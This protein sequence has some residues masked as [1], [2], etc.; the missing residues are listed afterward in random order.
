MTSASG[1]GRTGHS[2]H[3]RPYTQKFCEVTGILLLAAE[4][5]LICNHGPMDAAS[6]GTGGELFG[7]VV[8]F[9]LRSGHEP[10]F[11]DLVAA[12]MTEIARHEP[13]TLLYVSHTVEGEPR[14]RVFYELYRTLA[15]FE[16][17]ER[18]SHVRHFLAE[19]EALVERVEVDRVTP[20]AHTG[21]RAGSAR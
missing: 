13:E 2:T 8:R 20:V 18:Q 14:A 6:R 21:I 16:A 19:R 7:L 9:T 17:H 15:G 3:G 4:L 11:D 12:T 5:L 1:A 10:A